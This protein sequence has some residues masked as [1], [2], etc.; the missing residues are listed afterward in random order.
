MTYLSLALIVIVLV[1]PIT[2]IASR[3]TLR[4]WPAAALAMAALIIL[5]AVFDNVM[6]AVD[7]FGYRSDHLSGLHLGLAPIEDFAWPVVGALL[8]PA[9]WELLSEREQSGTPEQPVQRESE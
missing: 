9:I 4:F 7:L 2:L 3:R 5:T 1:I 6:I 8:L